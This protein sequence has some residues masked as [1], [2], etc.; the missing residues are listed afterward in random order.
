MARET[1]EYSFAK[2]KGPENYKQ[3][4]RDMLFALKEAGLEGY[5]TGIV[6]QLPQLTDDQIKELGKGIDAQ[7]RMER[8][9]EARAKWS[10]DDNRCVGKIG[11]MCTSSLQTE[12]KDDWNAQKVWTELKSRCT[13]RGWSAKWSLLTEFEEA[14]YANSK[15][16]MD[17]GQ[18]VTSLLEE[19]EDQ[20][21]TMREY[22]IIIKVINSMSSAFDTY[23]SMSSLSKKK[24]DVFLG[25]KQSKLLLN[26]D[27]IG[28][29]DQLD[30]QH[31][32]YGIREEGVRL[33]ALTKKSTDISI[34]HGRTAHLGY[35]NVEKMVKLVDGM[36]ELVGKTSSLV[37][38]CGFCMMGRQQAE[39][40]RVPM[41]R[42]SQFLELLHLDLEGPLP[43]TWAGGYRY[44]LLIKDDHTLLT[45]VYPL[46]LKGEAFSKLVEFKNQ[47]ENQADKKV[48]RLRVDG[49]GEFRGERWTDLC[50]TSGIKCEYSTPYTPQ[51]N[52]RSERSMYTLMSPL[53]AIL[54]EKRLPKSLWAELVRAIAYVKNRCPGV[55]EVTPFQMANGHKPDVSNLRVLGCRTWVH[56]PNTT[57]RHKLDARAWQGIMVGYEGSNQWRVYN[58]VDHKV[59]VVRD[60]K[61]DEGGRYDKSLNA[62]NEDLVESWD[63]DDDLTFEEDFALVDRAVGAGENSPA[64][65]Y[66]TPKSMESSQPEV[67]VGENEDVVEEGEDESELLDLLPTTSSQLPEDPLPPTGYRPTALPPSSEGESSVT[68]PEESVVTTR[69]AQRSREPTASSERVT[70]SADPGRSRP[71][72]KKLNNGT[73]KRVNLLTSKQCFSSTKVAKSHI[74]M[75]RVLHALSSGETLGLGLAHEEPRTYK[76]AMKS[77]DW[78]QWKNAMEDEF[79]SLTENKTWDLVNLPIKRNCLTGRWVFKIKLG[80]NGVI[81]KYKARWVVHGYKQEYGVDY[82]ETWSGVVKPPTFRT[83]F[84]IAA[85]RDLHIEQMDVVTA[86][87]YGFLDEEVFVE[88]PHGFAESPILVCLLR[89][90]LYGLK[91]APR[92]WSVMLRNYLNKLGFYE[93]ESDKSLFVSEDK[94]MFIAVYVDDLLIFGKDM[95]RIDLIKDGLKDQFK[96]TDLGAASHYLGMEIRRN[97]AGFTIN[98]V[99]TT[100]LNKVVKKFGF[101]GCSTVSTPMDPGLLNSVMPSITQADEDTIRWYGAAVGSLMYAMVTTRPDIAFALSVVSKYCSNPSAAHVG[102]VDRIFKYIAGTTEIGLTFDGSTDLGLVGY[103]DADYNGA[104]DGRC[105]TGGWLYLFAGGPISWSSKRQSAPAQSTCEAEYMALNEAGKEAIW[106]RYILRDLGLI[107]EADST[108]LWG[109]NKGSISLSGNPEFHRKTKHIESKWHWIRKQVE[110]GVLNIQYIPTKLMAADGLTKALPPMAF[111]TFRGMMNML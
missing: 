88:Q 111:R 16:V 105:S 82:A 41:H 67:T 40:S 23:V 60:V 5:L 22:Y 53:R 87:L 84:G 45:F 76:Q 96:M 6:K 29:I 97:R 89:K 80:I 12:I 57:F 13:P 93:T 62:E 32:L 33:M 49:G 72:Y 91:Q 3:W 43:T 70:R 28:Y 2:L 18:Q 26:G 35:Q 65:H 14:N 9:D 78:P 54:K 90:A 86:F 46:K 44:F 102:A 109:D 1:N 56:V 92:V 50:H 69:S 58:P 51:Q 77:P 38:T 108:L 74:H 106:L 107:K 20:S 73:T 100:Y 52:G 75:V 83:V 95:E 104:I 31:Q 66:P 27:V 24:I 11:R 71:D 19:I 81:L 34:W 39:I 48:K 101:E 42:A 47:M 63:P 30:K 59:H 8:R 94:Q 10:R 98:L 85:H 25:H 64:A 36:D 110:L 7:E 21:I 4:S 99:Q 61:F 103:S 15:G 79:N 68:A 17:F 37:E 55:D